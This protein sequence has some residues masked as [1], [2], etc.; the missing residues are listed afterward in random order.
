MFIDGQSRYPSI[1]NK[2]KRTGGIVNKYARGKKVYTNQGP[3]K[4]RIR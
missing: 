2:K 1:T 4:A 3:R